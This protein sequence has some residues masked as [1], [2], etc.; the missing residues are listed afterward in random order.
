MRQR[1][2]KVYPQDDGNNCDG[3]DFE[4]RVCA[5]EPCS[6][7]LDKLHLS[8]SLDISQE[9]SANRSAKASV[10]AS[11]KASSKKKTVEA[12]SHGS[13]TTDDFE[14][15]D[16][17]TENAEIDE[18]AHKLGKEIKEEKK[19]MKLLNTSKADTSKGTSVLEFAGGGGGDLA[20]AG[21]S[22][23]SSKSL[24]TSFLAH[25]GLVTCTWVLTPLLL[26]AMESA[27]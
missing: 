20:A 1:Y 5:T 13:R 8:D 4:Q 25:H 23:K 12:S 9:A 10:N 24:A 15:S 27:L 7:V 18:I 26:A 21:E 11:T 2:I 14:V 6:L 3:P 22:E 17:A 19:D 16:N